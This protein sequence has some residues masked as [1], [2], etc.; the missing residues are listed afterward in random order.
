MK[1]L[2]GALGAVLI[3]SALVG[4]GGVSQG[5]PLTAN[6]FHRV[7]HI[8]YGEE[9]GS[10]FT[11]EHEGKQY[12]I[13]AGHVVEGFK[14][15][16]KLGIECGKTWREIR[17]GIVGIETGGENGTDLHTLDLAVLAPDRKLSVTYPMEARIAGMSPGGR[18][19]LMGFPLRL[20][21]GA[22]KIN[23]MRPLP[24]PIGGTLVGFRKFGK[25]QYLLVDA[26]NNMGMSGGPVVWKAEEHGGK[27]ENEYAVAGVIRG[28]WQEEK[29][30]K[31]EEGKV[32]GKVSINTGL[33]VVVDI[34][35]AIEWIK[36]KPIGYKAE[37][38]MRVGEDEAK[39]LDCRTW[40]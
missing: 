20:G 14:E 31:D 28:Y 7:F 37:P 39:K 19:T 23:W 22:E 33:A 17:A 34:K 35:H 11:L 9:T 2:R 21:G 10:A 36:S 26:S 4:T 38:Q 12:L 29:T 32:I 40:Q 1:G 8:M 16:E 25:A 27:G 3:G 18:V 15:G 13:T 30:V 6:V 5:E 24:L